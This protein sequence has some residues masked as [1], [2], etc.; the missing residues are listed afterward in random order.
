MEATCFSEVLIDFQQTTW[1]N[2]PEDRILNVC[3]SGKLYEWEKY[4]HWNKNMQVLGGAFEGG[5]FIPSLPYF[6]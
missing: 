4:Q 5:M 3:N 1:H 2:I 6:I